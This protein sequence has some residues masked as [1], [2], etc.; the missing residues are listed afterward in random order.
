MAGESRTNRMHIQQK[1]TNEKHTLNKLQ[2]YKIIMTVREIIAEG[3][4]KDQGK[5]RRRGSSN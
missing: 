4:S 1:N 2:K 5:G 3:V